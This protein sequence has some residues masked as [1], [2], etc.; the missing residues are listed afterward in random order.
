MAATPPCPLF[1]AMEARVAAIR[2]KFVRDQLVAEAADPTSTG[3]VDRLAAF[4][5]LAHAEIEDYREGKARQ[6]L[7]KLDADYAAGA[8]SVRGNL[9]VLVI[10]ALLGKTAR[11]E[12]TLWT[13][14]FKDVVA[15]AREVIS[16]N[17]GIK[18]ASFTSLAVFCGKMPDE[19]DVSLAAALT[20]FG[21]QR[22]DVAH[23][24]VMRVRTILA[25][26]AE[27]KQAEDLLEGL[28]R[29]FY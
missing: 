25:P 17:N 8:T 21:K 13:A 11:F 15:T 29:F 9:S 20:S 6:A 28:K 12:T 27:V 22:G 16:N 5:L 3:D 10:G 23:K 26:S 1:L 18:E 19:I 14:F 2:E 24:S 4:R 7:D